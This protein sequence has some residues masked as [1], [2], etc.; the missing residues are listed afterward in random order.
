MELKSTYQGTA[1]LHDSRYR[2]WRVGDLLAH[3]KMTNYNAP[4]ARGLRGRHRDEG[5][6]ERSFCQVW[7][8]GHAWRAPGGKERNRNMVQGQGARSESRSRAQFECAEALAASQRAANKGR[9]PSWLGCGPTTLSGVPRCLSRA[10]TPFVPT[11]TPS[12]SATT[13]N[14][15]SPH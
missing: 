10:P 4:E 8:P 14:R 15:P 1:L 5:D 11:S 6:Q 9:G 13:P 12:S 2:A 3:Y 7:R